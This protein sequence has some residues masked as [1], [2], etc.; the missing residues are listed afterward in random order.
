MADAGMNQAELAD[1]IG[2]TRQ[3]LS[4]RMASG[5]FTVKEICDI[6]RA[7]GLRD[8]VDVYNVFIKD[9][10]SAVS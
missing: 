3:S 9:M 4:A 6:C 5:N 10:L 2:M 8:P 1:A 7:T